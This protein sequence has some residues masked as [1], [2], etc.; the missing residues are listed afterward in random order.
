M[1]NTKCK[2]KDLRIDTANKKVFYD[3]YN[4]W[5]YVVT[6]VQCLECEEKHRGLQ[7]ICIDHGIEQD[8]EILYPRNCEHIELEKV[9][10][11]DEFN[12]GKLQCKMCLFS[13]P[14]K[15]IDNNWNTDR[16]KLLG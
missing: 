10:I 12:T 13:I 14:I 6:N 2:H 11:D 15:K 8:W 9:N 1:G 3:K 5:K 4:Y 16:E 7:K